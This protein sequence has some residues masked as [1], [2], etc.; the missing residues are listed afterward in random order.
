MS[1][2]RRNFVVG[3]AAGLGQAV[4]SA[5]LTRAAQLAS[6]WRHP[7]RAVLFDAF[8]IFDPR[9]ALARADA[10]H[11][12]LA[13]AWRVRQFEYTWLRTAARRYADFWQV[14]QD[15]LTFAARQLRVTLTADARDTLMQSY[16]H[17]PAWDDVHEAIGTLSQRGLRLGF[18]SNFTTAMLDANIA[19][20]G[21]G[22]RFEHVISTDRAAT[23][24]PDPRAYQLGVE[25]LGL[26]RDEILFVAF[27]G[28]DAA[29]AT[30][31]GYPTY[32]VNRLRAPD[33]ELGARADAGGETLSDLARYLS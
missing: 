16:L 15:A 10:V 32:W 5:S 33:E 21:L 4:L 30:L 29:G 8:P 26:R 17:L 3:S 28:W 11:P 24:K 2:S 1:M 23:Y 22:G 25:A 12:G 7:Y 31:F 14:T 20:A 9:P 19:S 13:D 27:A 6:G 18:L